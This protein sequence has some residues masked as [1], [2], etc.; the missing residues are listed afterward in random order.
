[1]TNVLVDRHHADLLY[2]LQLMFEDRLGYDLFV[3]MGHEWWDEWYWRFGAVF[4]DDR[5]AQQFLAVQGEEIEPGLYLSF[6]DHHPE[7]PVY[8]VSLER[9]KGMDWEAVVATVDDNQRGF[10]KFATEHAARY[11]YHIGNARQY[12]DEG[13]APVILDGPQLFDFRRTFRYRKPVRMDRI[14]SFVNLLPFIQEVADG[15]YVCWE[16]FV[17][18]QERLPAYSFASFGHDCPDGLLKPVARIAEEMAHAG[19]AFH[20]K[21]TGDGFG[22]ILANWAAVGRPLIGHASYYKG[23]WGESLWE[24]KR[25]CLDLDRHSIEEAASMIEDTTPEQHEWMCEAIREQFA[26]MD[27]EHAASDRSLVAS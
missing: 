19:W 9:A 11:L 25:T 27:I 4:G 18:L 20:D 10:H 2:A 26:S 5:L 13:L 12:I 15:P 1:M 17:G 24:D 22:H 23:Q 3:P 14:V 6:D 7:R 8:G 16:R 21:P